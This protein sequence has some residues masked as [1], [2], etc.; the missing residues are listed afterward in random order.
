MQAPVSDEMEQ[1]EPVAKEGKEA[2]GL[3]AGSRGTV[4]GW[5]PGGLSLDGH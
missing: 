2:K 5:P 4:P 1:G 3:G